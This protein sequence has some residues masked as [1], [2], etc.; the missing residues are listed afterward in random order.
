MEEFSN[1][2]ISHKTAIPLKH[3]IQVPIYCGIYCFIALFIKLASN[4]R[5]ML[6]LYS[7][8][9]ISKAHSYTTCTTSIQQETW[10]QMGSFIGLCYI[11]TQE[12]QREKPAANP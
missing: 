6:F 10:E 11:E 7:G 2:W 5:L 9:T 4:V 12:S 3:K 8:H 1:S